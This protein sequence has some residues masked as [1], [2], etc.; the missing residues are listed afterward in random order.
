MDRVTSFLPEVLLALFALLSMLVLSFVFGMPISL[1]DLNSLLFTGMSLWAP[2]LAFTGLCS[3]SVFA[4]RARQVPYLI[5][6]LL[7]YCVILVAHFNTKLWMTAINPRLFD[8]QYWA[9]DQAL[10]P[11]IDASFALHRMMG[12]NGWENKLYLFA[13]LAMYVCSLI[14]HSLRDF[15]ILRKIVFAS[16]LIHVLGGLGY[17]IAPAIGPFLYEPGLNEIATAQQHYMISVYQGVASGGVGWLKANGA[18][19]MMGAPAA[20]PSLHVASSAVFV[21]YAWRQQRWLCWLYIPLFVFI[22]AEAMATRWHYLADLIV[23]FALTALCLLI[24]DRVFRY[25]PEKPAA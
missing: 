4:G 5:S 14:V 13:F 17:L 20:M 19:A 16:M 25:R 15:V 2:V 7:L 12:T 24:S 1:P 11:V 21:W 6:A 8:K 23:G 22:V 9:I 10:R 3:V 18:L